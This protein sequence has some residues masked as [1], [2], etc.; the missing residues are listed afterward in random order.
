MILYRYRFLFGLIKSS[1]KIRFFQGET[2]PRFSPVWF[3]YFR[4]LNL[5]V[6]VFKKKKSLRVKPASCSNVNSAMSSLFSEEHPFSPMS[7]AHCRLSSLSF[8]R[9]RTVSSSSRTR[10][11][12]R[13]CIDWLK[14]QVR[15]CN[16][17]DRIEPSFL[18][19]SLVVRNYI[20]QSKIE[21]HF[22]QMTIEGERNAK[23]EETFVFL[24]S[25]IYIL[26][27]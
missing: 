13:V 26:V 9:R 6:L 12:S 21:F 7:L 20:F 14:Y 17:Q 23:L 4:P 22:R 25:A 11:S 15:R 18:S 2:L 5:E 24:C 3:I 8:W 27:F 16:S 10:S 1:K 19:I